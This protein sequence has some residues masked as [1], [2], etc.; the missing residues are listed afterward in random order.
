MRRPSEATE[1]PLPL[2]RAFVVHLR[3]RS[4]V[5]AGLFVGRVE[6]IVSG[7]AGRFAS[8]ADLVEF[9]TRILEPQQEEQ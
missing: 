1:P 9:V 3:P 2:E 4:D 5:A 6:H 7:A 8:A